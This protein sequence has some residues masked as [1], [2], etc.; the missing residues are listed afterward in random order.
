MKRNRIVTAM[1]VFTLLTGKMNLQAQDPHYS[2]YFMSPMTLNP[3]LT[4][5]D[6]TEWR[7]MGNFRSQ[8]WG[9]GG[10]IAPF[11]TTA[12]SL[13]KSFVSGE[14][15][16]SNLGIGLSFLTDASNSGLLKSNY[17]TA[18]VAYHIATDAKGEQQL[19]IGMQFS[20]AN[21]L[22]DA[23]K[24]EFQS[25]F[26][27]MGFQ[28]GIS[29]GD[30]VSTFKNTY[31][32]V[33]AGFNYSLNSKNFGF[34]LG[35]AVFHSSNPDMGAYQGSSY[36]L[37]R[38]YTVQGSMYFRTGSQDMLVF[39][40]VRDMQNG[41]SINTAG[42]MYKIGVGQAQL[43]TLNVG[44]WNRFSDALYPYIGL[45]GKHWLLG[46]SYDIISSQVETSYNSV[47]S[48]EVSLAWL[49]GKAK[50]G[51]KRSVVMY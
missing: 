13:E 22:I 5:K 9:G 31:L 27:S 46:I 51:A 10:G 20:Y 15:K 12:A 38:R 50:A 7:A 49:F 33:N 26:G 23:S 29:Y 11:Y 25:Q 48:M 32:D 16:T 3:A 1:L 6:V 36:S 17:F 34:N 14:S 28:H 2:Q 41:N 37:P 40:G 18:G 30:P 43:Q 4:A 45:E 47:Q 24:F 8:W 42:I 35:A 44:V 21:R 39:S 19:S